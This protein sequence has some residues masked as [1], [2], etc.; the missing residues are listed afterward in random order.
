MVVAARIVAAHGDQVMAHRLA[1]EGLTDCRPA[2]QRSGLKV[3]VRT[4]GRRFWLAPFLRRIWLLDRIRLLA[5]RIL[6]Q[7][8]GAMLVGHDNICSAITINIARGDL[9]TD[10][11]IAVEQRHLIVRP[12]GIAT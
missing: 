11:R 2:T 9:C 4:T 5:R 8:V 6:A 1:M 7:H 10:T 12:Q 3:Q